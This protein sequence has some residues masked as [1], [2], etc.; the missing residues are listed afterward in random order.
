MTSRQ[1]KVSVGQPKPSIPGTRAL[2]SINK[3]R[4]RLGLEEGPS[5]RQKIEDV[6]EYKEKAKR[7]LGWQKKEELEQVD[8]F[9][10][11]NEV[12]A[13]KYLAQI[14]NCI[15]EG[16]KLEK[17]DPKREFLVWKVNQL[18]KRIEELAR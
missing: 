5:K 18:I 3:I 8:I 10:M 7:V 6:E 16:Y 15:D 13:N 4:K 2:Q 14:R 11:G 1:F 17:W 12:S 9:T